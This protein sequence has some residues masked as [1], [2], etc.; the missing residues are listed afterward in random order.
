M[1]TALP[2]RVVELQLQLQMAGATEV[3]VDD[4]K[5]PQGE[6]YV[7]FLCEGRQDC[8]M[9]KPD[10]GYGLW[11]GFSGAYGQRPHAYV[12]TAQEAV[13]YWKMLRT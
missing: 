12:E 11:S 4:P 5:D 3:K 9:W 13:E 10:R 2:L 8:I 1:S 6:W 7:D